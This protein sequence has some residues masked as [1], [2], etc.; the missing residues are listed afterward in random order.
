MALQDAAGLLLS[1]AYPELVDR[2]EFHSGTNAIGGN[3]ILVGQLGWTA[4]FV[5]GVIFTASDPISHWWPAAAAALCVLVRSQLIRNL[6]RGA[7]N[8]WNV[9]IQN[10]L[11]GAWA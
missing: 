11:G 8:T 5:F 4:A 7:N 2:S 1:Y 9:Q 6:R 10:R 3:W